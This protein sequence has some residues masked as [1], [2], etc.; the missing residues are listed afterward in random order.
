MKALKKG[1]IVA[2]ALGV[3]G[4]L[5]VRSLHS[6]RAEPYEVQ[7]SHLRGWTLAAESPGSPTGA[8]LSLRPP[9]ALPPALF[10]QIFERAMES[11][12]APGVSGMPLVL[13]HEFEQAFEGRVAAERLLEMARGAGLERE[14][15]E[16]MCLAHRRVSDPGVTRFV[17]A[18][19]FRSP[20]YERFRSDVAALARE[21]AGAASVFDP[22]AQSPLVIIGASDA[23]FPRWLPWRVTESE[24][25]APLVVE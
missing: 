15:L 11:L 3:L 21:S 13:S 12:A 1:L 23:S 20:A 19:A 16:P 7:V 18:A 2:V 9:A 6:T 14:P 25:L 10:K 4:Y 8:V 24:C 22:A 17:Y 5:F